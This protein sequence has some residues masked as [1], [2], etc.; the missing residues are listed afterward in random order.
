MKLYKG[1]FS[2]MNRLKQNAGVGALMLVIAFV[3]MGAYRDHDIDW[4]PQHH[5]IPATDFHTTITEG[6]PNTRVSANGGGQQVELTTIGID[7]VSMATGDFIAT[8]RPFW[9]DV[10]RNYPLG[11]R[12]WWTSNS[13]ATDGSIDWIVGLEEKGHGAALEAITGLA[14]QITMDADAMSEATALIVQHTNWDTLSS[15]AI[16]TYN[17]GT[18]MQISVELDDSGDASADEVHFLGVEFAY[19]PNRTYGAG[20]RRLSSVS[21]AS[22]NGSAGINLGRRP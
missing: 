8:Y 14:D 1:G 7:A 20:S 17:H 5:F 16:G 4:K 21:I 11:M 2:K 13:A 15:T 10:N 6:T 3:V 19:V 9:P 22:A 18:M 12:V